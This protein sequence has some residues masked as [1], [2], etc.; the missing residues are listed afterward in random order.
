MVDGR[1]VIVVIRDDSIIAIAI[2]VTI[3]IVI[4]IDG[5][6]LPHRIMQGMMNTMK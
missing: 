3:T 5:L 6:S 1:I 2:A 4:V